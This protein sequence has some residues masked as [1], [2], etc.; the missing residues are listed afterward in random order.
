LG[1]ECREVC[2]CG[3]LG[4]GQ[5]GDVRELVRERFVPRFNR[6]NRLLSRC[7]CSS[8]L[9]AAR[10]LPLVGARCARGELGWLPGATTCAI[11]DHSSFGCSTFRASAVLCEL[12]VCAFSCVCAQ[13]GV[14]VQD[15]CRCRCR[16]R[17]RYYTRMGMGRAQVREASRR[18]ASALPRHAASS[19]PHPPTCI[20]PFHMHVVVE[21]HNRCPSASPMAPGS[22]FLDS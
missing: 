6:S 8:E 13:F 17:C 3:R 10:F 21:A 20:S 2:R 16:C 15:H 18:I 12:M 4:R 5:R 11:H 1:Q 19:H 14:V 22:D 9:S 7:S